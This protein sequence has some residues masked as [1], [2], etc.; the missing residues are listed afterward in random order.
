MT[1]QTYRSKTMTNVTSFYFDVE[2]NTKVFGDM[3][4]SAQVREEVP[5]EI[6]ERLLSIHLS[7]KWTGYTGQEIK[8]RKDGSY[9][10]ESKSGEKTSHFEK[11][12]QGK[13]IL[14]LTMAS[15]YFQGDENMHTSVLFPSENPWDMDVH[16]IE[17]T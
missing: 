6:I 17:P 8:R 16:C 11:A 14:V 3:Q 12:Y 10:R 15:R 5:M 13:T 7:A 9:Y 1:L 4:I 2:P